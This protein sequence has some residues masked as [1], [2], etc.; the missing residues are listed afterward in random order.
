MYYY[1]QLSEQEFDWIMQGLDPAE[2]I[3]KLILEKIESDGDEY[4][5]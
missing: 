5:Y 1:S 2:E 4:V 3:H